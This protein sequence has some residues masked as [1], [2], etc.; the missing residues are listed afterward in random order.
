MEIMKTLKIAVWLLSAALFG[1]GAN[2]HAEN[3]KIVLVAGKPSHGP[4]EHE[5]N[6]GVL[7]LK[8]C[9]DK[10]PRLDV[11][12]YTN[13]WPEDKDAFKG[14]DAVVLYMDG[15]DNHPAIQDKRLE[16][17][18]QVLKRGAGL[19][20]LHYAVE[21][22]KD[23]G[24]YE[25]LNW[26]GGYFETYWSINPTW[27]ADFKELPKHPI[28]RGVKPFK[29]R[30]EWYYHMRF[31]EEHVTPILSAVPPDS[32]REGKDDAHGGN[33]FVRARKGMAEVTAWAYDRPDGG[34]GFGFTG[35]HFHK[36]WGNDDVRKLVL[37]AILWI[38]HVDVPEDGVQSTVTPEELEKNLDPK[39][40]K[41]KQASA[42]AK[43]NYKSGL[44]Q[45]GK[46][47]VRADIAGAKKLYLVVTDGGNGIGCDWADWLE[48]KLL[49]SDGSSVPLTSLKWK[50][51]TAGW[52]QPQAGKNVAGGTLKIGEGAFVDGIG[53]HAPSLIE[54]DLPENFARFEAKAGVDNG[55]T[56][57]NC[58]A[59]VEFMVFTQK[60]PESFLQVSSAAPGEHAFG[61]QAARESIG[62]FTVA[63]GLEVSLFAAEPMLR[64]PTDMDIDERGRVWI[65]EG[66][67]Y[68]STFQPWGTLQPAGDKVIVLEDTD[69]DGVADKQTVFYQGPDINSALGICVLG[70]KVIVSRSPNVFVLTDTDGDGKADKKEILFSGIGG[71]DHDHGVHAFTFG[72]D[73]KLY[74]CFG[75]L[76]GQLLD[77]DGKPVRD[78]EGNP[79]SNTGEP[80]R[81]G[82]V[83]RCNVDGSDVEVLAYNFRNNYEVAVDSFG[84]LWQSDN[85]DDGNRATRINYVMEHGNFGYTDELTGAGWFEKR[86]N[87]EKDIPSR[88]WHLNDPGVVPN[89]LMTGA[90]APTGILVY[91][92]NLLPE[93][94]R[95]QMIHADALTRV[96]RSY[97]VQPDGA[98]Y[99]AET[100]NILTTSDTWFRPS[101]VCIAPDGS[102]YVADWNDATVGGHD[103][104]DRDLAKM[105]GRVYR[106]APAGAKASVPKLDLKTAAGC[107]A[108][109]QSPNLST[110]YLAWT[111]LKAMQ[112]DGEKELLKVWSGKGDPRMRARALYVLAEIPGA[113]DKYVR[114]AVKD[115]NP[116][117]R[118]TGL[119]VAR[120]KSLD[121][122][123]YVKK[124]VDDSSA[125]VRREC[126]IALRHNPSPEAAKLWA[127]LAAQHDGKDRWYLEALG[128]GADKQEDRFFDAWL[129]KVGKNWNTPAGRD[130]VWRSR[131]GKSAELLAQIIMDPATAE[132]ERARYLRAFDFIK[133][134]EKKAA[135]V[136]LLTMATK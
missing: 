111:T 55:G 11:V 62:K 15:G 54:Y 57:Q 125:Q 49:R 43:P 108:A 83:F 10:L 109:L 126:A 105:T 19:A 122:I 130:I 44:I 2:A 64:N 76:G 46:V 5:F 34:R 121:V 107:V 8:G 67:N 38:A 131:A 102:L 99:R 56:E 59:Q 114:Q 18:H 84:T 63:P 96:V 23:K 78:I 71:V 73:G 1:L 31:Q 65:T 58:G 40:G 4:G 113:A 82:M 75:N 86:T 41:K 30:D 115:K 52:N 129:A 136:E 88:H 104:A 94:F 21:V 53:T 36:N 7:L 87:L 6:A 120:E 68:R 74:F 95:G 118:I 26:I 110:R 134:P 100:V 127:E 135:L 119:R 60:P 50:S 80:Y 3:K 35:G 17:L 92:G 81:Q 66:V 37:N 33:E 14:A 123:S 12:A 45:S 28:T 70:N 24:G 27:E 51:A 128:I 79:V 91:E 69:S 133:G 39:G 106:V 77:R 20:C 29:I 13:G 90:G 103:M 89:L 48:P 112:H 9:L 32:T 61:M 16:Q 42:P 72:P 132:S 25:L 116:D 22:P 117:L 47:D 97:P 101:D 93:I 98:G 124:L 85:D